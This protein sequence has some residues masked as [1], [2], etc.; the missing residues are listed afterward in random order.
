VVVVVAMVM[1]MVVFMI[2]ADVIVAEPALD[3]DL[4][5]TTSVTEMNVGDL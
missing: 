1:V 2:A 4:H 5:L 3:N